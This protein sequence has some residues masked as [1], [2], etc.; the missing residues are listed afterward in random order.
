MNSSNKTDTDLD[1]EAARRALDYYL[2]PTP[3][4]PNLEHTLWTL[5]EGVTHQ[6][7]NDHA[8]QLLRCAAATAHETGTHLQGTTR[9]VM[10]ALMHMINMARALL[11]Q[12]NAMTAE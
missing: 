3:T 8:L 7:A 5:R 11:E 6:Q 4:T 2:N 1:A 9:E 10:F 12:R